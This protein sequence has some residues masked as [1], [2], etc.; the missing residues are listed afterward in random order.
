MTRT[1]MALAYAWRIPPAALLDAHPSELGAM[2]AFLE[3]I[4][5]DPTR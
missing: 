4:A 2:A 3:Q 1:R 5:P